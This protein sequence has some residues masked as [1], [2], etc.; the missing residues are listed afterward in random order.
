M[1]YSGIIHAKFLKTIRCSSEGSC[2]ESEISIYDEVEIRIWNYAIKLANK[3]SPAGTW[4]KARSS[5]SLGDWK[6]IVIPSLFD[7][8]LCEL[9]RHE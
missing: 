9:L 3:K 1:E 4:V 8:Y 5:F 2:K 7:V 6:D